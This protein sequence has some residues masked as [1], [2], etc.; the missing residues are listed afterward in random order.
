MG[1]DKR[2]HK[3]IKRCLLF[4]L[5]IALV[6]ACNSATINQNQP[7]DLQTA[8]SNCRAVQH[9]LGETC[10]PVNPQRVVVLSAGLDTVLSLGVKP[11]GSLHPNREDYYLNN[12]LEG[13]ENI[14]GAS[15]PNLESI[16]DLK[17]DLILGI[18]SD[19]QNYELLSQIAP[20]VLAEWRTGN[21]GGKLL[22]KY[23]EALGK[24][25]KAEQIMA[26]YDA[27][28]ETFQAQM[29]DRLQQTEVSLVRVFP[30][31]ILIYLE[32][33]Y[34]GA[35]IADAGLPRPDHQTEINETYSA[36]FGRELF[37]KA[38]GD[39]I[40]VWAG[41]VDK[42]RAQEV[43]TALKELKADPLWSRLDAVQQGRVYDGSDHWIGVGPIAA[44]LILDDLF[45]Y[46]VDSPSQASQ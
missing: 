34:C 17:P 45:K 29:G 19:R 11:I 27:R 38:D 28:I 23:A 24:T 39:V 35:V 26:D 31:R 10:V 3:R 46:L 9:E 13:V 33:S 42:E 8:S 16:V 32:D 25:G 2:R 21:D 18:E 41:G 44:N 15:G 22:D 6:S 40:F 4:L 1:I 5:T 30:D 20:T 14:S 7:S 37:H 43:Q 36:W 12:R